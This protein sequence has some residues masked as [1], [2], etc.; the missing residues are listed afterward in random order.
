MCDSRHHGKDLP[1]PPTAVEI[2]FRDLGILSEIFDGPS[3]LRFVTCVIQG[4]SFT[5]L[6]PMN[7]HDARFEGYDGYLAPTSL[8]ASSACQAI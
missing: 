7:A 8:K 6:Y 4:T 1:R 3:F 5:P 2:S